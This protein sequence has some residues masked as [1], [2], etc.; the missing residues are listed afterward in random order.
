MIGDYLFILLINLIFYEDIAG[1]C[2]RNIFVI[3][4]TLVAFIHC[5]I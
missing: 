5:K 2:H 4:V 1:Y 3:S